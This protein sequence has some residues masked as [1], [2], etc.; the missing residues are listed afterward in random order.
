MSAAFAVGRRFGRFKDRRLLGKPNSL[1]HRKNRAITVV[2]KKVTIWNG[3]A[4]VV[5]YAQKFMYIFICN[6]Y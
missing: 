3:I 5:Y 2:I 4:Q 6:V 1:R